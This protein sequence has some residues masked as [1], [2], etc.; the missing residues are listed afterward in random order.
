MTMKHNSS[1]SVAILVLDWNHID[2]Y[3]TDGCSG[4]PSDVWSTAV[5]KHGFPNQKLSRPITV[6]KS[7]K[8]KSWELYSLHEARKDSKFCCKNCSTQINKLY[9]Q[10][11]GWDYTN[12]PLSTINSFYSR[13]R[14]MDGSWESQPITFLL[15]DKSL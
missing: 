1:L 7:W 13:S 3:W 10:K 14:S 5:H 8:R 15:Q 11:S 9:V 12:Q 6:C 2:F 4:A